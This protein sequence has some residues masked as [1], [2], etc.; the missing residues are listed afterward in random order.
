VDQYNQYM[1]KISAM[2][3]ALLKHGQNASKKLEDNI[4]TLQ[5]EYGGE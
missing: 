3:T 5:D 2:E 1:K 4:K